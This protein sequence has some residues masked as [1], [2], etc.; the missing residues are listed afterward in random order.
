MLYLVYLLSLFILTL[1]DS[2]KHSNNSNFS[3]RDR[4]NDN[5]SGSCVDQYKSPGW[6]KNCL[7]ANLNGMYRKTSRNDYTE[8]HWQKWGKLMPLKSAKMMIRPKQPN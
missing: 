5:R 8:L 2:L 4:D 3:T 7:V 1:G 6:M